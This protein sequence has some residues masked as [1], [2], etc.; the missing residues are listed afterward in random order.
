MSIVERPDGARIWW[1]DEG[2]GEP[3]VLVMGLGYPSDMWFRVT[4]A[5]VAGGHRVLRLDNRGAGRTGDVPGAP[6]TVE[7]MAADVLA[8]L[9]AA[10][11]KSAHV[12]GVSMG[13][14]VAQ[15]IGL[16]APARARSLV[17]G[18]THPG[19]AKAEWDREALA[20][21]ADR[22]SLTPAEAAERSIPF[23]YAAATPRERIEEDWAVR[24][25]LACTAAGYQAQVNGTSAWSGLDRLPSLRV[26]TLVLHGE[27]DRLVPVANGRRIAKAVPKAEL[28]I[29]PDANHLFFT[30][31]P[32]RTNEIVLDWLA[33]HR[34]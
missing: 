23:N 11:E 6:Y 27:Q 22:G 12:I 9:D 5:L 25:P 7:T 30:D 26:P 29:L 16:S 4:P 19:V 3:V 2:H 14:L 31:Q 33:R 32:E 34:G 8:V 21:L 13:G 10:G 28:T 1:T 15:E 20:L 24:L 17:L 18:C